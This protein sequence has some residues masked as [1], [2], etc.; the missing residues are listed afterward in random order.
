MSHVIDV[1]IDI[2]YIQESYAWT[3]DAQG[4]L[5]CSPT[6]QRHPTTADA[7]LVRVELLS[8][9]TEAEALMFLNK[10]G[11]FA[12]PS[13]SGMEASQ[14]GIRGLP[15]VLEWVK[16]FRLLVLSRP[17][18]W[19]YAERGEEPMEN[20]DYDPGFYGGILDD[21]DNDKA[22]A[23]VEHHSFD[24]RFNWAKQ[25]RAAMIFV[26]DALSA[27]LATVYIDKLRG[28]EYGFCARVDCG[29]LFKKESR[30][31]RKYCRWECGHLV[32]IRKGRANANKPESA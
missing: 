26:N 22:R 23:I 12:H 21:F 29:K 32:A 13:T 10:N 5:R 30:H 17:R 27:L 16:V 1:P 31:R 3:V 6:S 18:D 28:E 19:G 24:I 11:L 9:K 2:N 4:I 14:A 15:D 8:I 25:H 20:P 7:W